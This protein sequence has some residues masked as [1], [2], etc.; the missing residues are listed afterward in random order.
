LLIIGAYYIKIHYAPEDNPD[1]LIMIRP[2]SEEIMLKWH[3]ILH[4]LCS[5]HAEQEGNLMNP[6]EMIT[7]PA[8]YQRDKTNSVSHAN[9][10]AKFEG[11]I[12]I[13]NPIHSSRSGFDEISEDGLR[14]APMSRNGSSSNMSDYSTSRKPP[15]RF[16]LNPHGAPPHL[17]TGS[18]VS[19]DMQGSYFSPMDTP[20]VPSIS[21]QS[22]GYPQQFPF[23]QHRED[24]TMS[25]TG[26]RDGYS[27]G[28][29]TPPLTAML[30]DRSQSR[31]SIT[32]LT[33]SRS[34]S[35]ST[36][37]M[38]QIQTNV[39]RGR[40]DP[41]PLPVS[42]F[43][44]ESDSPVTPQ[45]PVSPATFSRP[46][47]GTS[48][49]TNAISSIPESATSMSSSGTAVTRKPILSMASSIANLDRASALKV[50][51]TYGS[52]MFAIVIPHD[53]TYS[54]LVSKVLHKLSVCSNV[55]KDGPIRMKYQD[56]DGDLVTISSDED[57][58]MALE[59]RHSANYGISG[60]GAINL[61]VYSSSI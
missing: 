42:R 1:A 2:R 6:L 10:Y 28:I 29:P 34:R 46:T 5:K 22:Q 31:P 8:K 50:K 55:P 15:S 21:P 51:I 11:R 25:R 27:N 39:G 13:S 56:E 14:S 35:A 45:S 26:S 37:N 9:G 7:N 41:P 3:S 40:D 17:R 33:T 12:D 38:H 24:G 20:P 58:A 18:L 23:P 43:D 19:P 59:S 16:P 30:P 32:P 47:T 54:A 53:V 61:L 48:T 4:D 44:R 52:D 49:F 60:P 36:P 57:V